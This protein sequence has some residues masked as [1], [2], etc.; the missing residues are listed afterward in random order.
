MNSHSS[1][2]HASVQKTVSES[3]IQFT[4]RCSTTIHIQASSS[5][6]RKE[7]RKY[8]KNGRN[9][10]FWLGHGRRSN[11]SSRCRRSPLA[12][13]P[14]PAAYRCLSHQQKQPLLPLTAARCLPLPLAAMVLSSG[15]RLHSCRP[16]SV[17]VT[18]QQPP[19]PPALVSSERSKTTREWLGL[20][21]RRVLTQR[22][23]ARDLGQR[24]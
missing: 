15:R 17:P 4:M 18:E 12:A 9:L 3:I 13:L 8:E 16:S 14:R 24:E 20:L 1:K 5:P 19:P 2:L 11:S 23:P 10:A 7:Q 21:H 22:G 6:I